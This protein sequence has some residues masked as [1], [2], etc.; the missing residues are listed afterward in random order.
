MI[1]FRQIL[2]LARRSELK[3]LYRL[4]LMPYA[5][6]SLLIG[7]QRV[8]N[9][10]VLISCGAL[11]AYIYQHDDRTTST[12]WLTITSCSSPIDILML[13]PSKEPRTGIFFPK[14]CNAMQF[15]GC[16]VRIKYGFVKVYAVGTY[17]DPM[18]MAAVKKQGPQAIEK[19]LLDPSYPRTIR[20]VM[21]R[22][23][24]T[25]KFTAAIVDALSP[26]MNG[27]NLDKLDEFQKLNP[28]LDLIQGA[29]IEMTIRG[30]TM[31]YKNCVGGVGQ[32][33]S[34]AFCVALCDIYY[35]DDA[36]SPDHKTNVVNGI[37]KL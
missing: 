5:D 19:A 30:D 21:N 2:N 9:V 32:I 28:P 1:R 18:A 33:H 34:H 24:S 10:L 37:P 12:S 14:L 27:E 6:R 11:S 15:V 36:V 3:G 23:L 7:N 20:I 26:R 31:L 17:V 29:E 25:E 22:G 16:G 13:E 35:G 4:N 8:R